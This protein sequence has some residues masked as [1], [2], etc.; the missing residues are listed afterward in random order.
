MMDAVVAPEFSI[1]GVFETEVMKN[2]VK[3]A[4]ADKSRQQARHES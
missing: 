4:V 3:R 1:P 2:V